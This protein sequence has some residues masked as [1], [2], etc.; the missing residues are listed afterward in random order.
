LLM[1]EFL[2]VDLDDLK[3]IGEIDKSGILGLCIKTW[4]LYEEALSF[5]YEVELPSYMESSGGYSHGRELRKVVVAGMGGSAIGGCLLRDMLRDEVGVPV[6]VVGGYTLPAYLDEETLVFV[7]SYSGNTE[8][9]LCSFVNA[10]RKRCLV[11]TVTSGGQLAS[12]SKRLNMPFVKVP[13]GLPPR[14]ALPYLFTPLPVILER[15]GLISSIKE[16]L[17]ESIQVLRRLA[18]ELAPEVP[19]RD[20]LAKSSA[21]TIAGTTPVVFGP[22]YYSSVAYRLKTQFNENSKTLSFWGVFPE[23]NHNEVMGWERTGPLHKLISIILLRDRD[24]AP[25][26]KE[27]I[28]I[29][30][31]LVFEKASNVI[32]LYSSGQSKI[33]RMLSL[34]FLGDLISV[35]LALVRGIDPTPV[36]TI[37]QMKKELR[38]KYDLLSK[39]EAEIRSME[40][41]RH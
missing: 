26:I 18:E 22:Y 3:E 4:V 20:N 30:K 6:E 32:E 25:Y 34:V 24:E 27:R 2:M 38:G 33:A 41:R 19:L 39:L 1:G 13:G 7:V 17:E 29:T 37:E 28:E 9:A 15:I 31:R 40:K 21:Q 12:F 8:E 11:C 10:V 35:Y 23:M 5:S 36:R 16:E 14:V